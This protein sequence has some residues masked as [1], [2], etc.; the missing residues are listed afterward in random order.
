MLAQPPPDRFDD[1]V[2]EPLLKRVFTAVRPPRARPFSEMGSSGTAVQGGYVEQ[3][4]KSA[5]WVGTQ[6]YLTIA[7][8]AVNTSIVAAGV[9][10]FLNL[11]A[12]PRWSVVPADDSDE[13]RAAADLVEDALHGSEQS[14]SRV[15]RR[16][17]TFRFYG[18]GV[19][20]WTAVRR[21]DGRV[22]LKSIEPRPQ[23]SIERWSVADD[24]AVEGVWQRRPGTG[25][26]LGIPRS[27]LLYLVDDALTDSP[28]GIGI[29]RHLAEPWG[30]LKG[31][32]DLE[33]RAFERDLRGIPI[34]RVPYAALNQAV[35]DKVITQ[36]QAQALAKP[37]QD[38]VKLAIKQSDTGLTLD[39]MPYE[40]EAADGR[41]VSTSMM[42]GLELLQGSSNGI[43]HL[44]AAIK[45]T[46]HEM[47]T[48]L[49]TTQLLYG[50][51][52]SA[53]NRSLGESMSQG[54]WLI[55]NA[56]LGDI[57]AGVD[58]DVVAPI[59]M[60]NGVPDELRPTTDVED[61]AFKD[62]E[63]IAGILR[64]MALAGAVLAPDDPAVDEV[65]SLVGLSPAS[66][67]PQDVLTGVPEV[68]EGEDEV[69]EV[70]EDPAVDPDTGEPVA[71]ALRT[72]FVRR[73]LLNVEDVRRWAA[74]Q[75][76]AS[77]LPPDDMHVTLA[78][79]REPVDWSTLRPDPFQ[80][81]VVA[82]DRDVH[83]FPPR[84]TP[85]GA[86]VLRFSS[87]ALERRWA[88]LL[89]AGASWDFP[90]YQPHVTLTYSLGEGEAAG[91]EPY[92]G[93]LVFGPELFS[94]VDDGWA[95]R[96]TEVPTSKSLPRV[97]SRRRR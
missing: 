83:Q 89:A 39:S 62:A 12:H 91:L 56:V 82:G 67:A 34:G 7:D 35:A 36:E 15:V 57:S 37:I 21:G 72:L 16:A 64:E 45:R 60:L 69:D 1:F 97:R 88:A 63:A 22:G 54:L 53:G 59:C 68:G 33:A 77:T 58:R 55:S 92:S 32:Y 38:F 3:R 14:W 6:R 61:V 81:T 30:R 84:L 46:L 50:M 52:G 20:E 70:D 2:R 65:R 85:N 29:L 76:I 48:L 79:S 31:Y 86:V 19:Q 13:A 26:Q 49:S 10:F 96:I 66:T 8:M 44:G 18:F 75:G 51:E 42:Y 87:I 78:F 71:K 24:G 90:E 80:V 94:E 4:E 17:G 74:G 27:K 43:E 5:A 25:E 9:H 11:I 95:G 23:H 73:R 41:K 40:S 93:P 47:A 28:E